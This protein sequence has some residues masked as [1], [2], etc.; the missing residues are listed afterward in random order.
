MRNLLMMEI[1]PTLFYK[2]MASPIGDLALFAQPDAR[3]R[4]VLVA[5]TFDALPPGNRYLE[6]YFKGCELRDAPL[7]GLCE[8]FEA[9][10]DGEAA[11][12]DTVE[13]SPRGT[14]FQEEVWR[15]LREI[16]AGGIESYA[17][18]SERIGRPQA[19]RAVAR[20]N[21]LNPV[22]LVVP[23][24]RV[25][26]KDG[27]LTGFGGGLDRKAWLLKHEGARSDPA[28]DLFSSL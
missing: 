27:S 9:Y 20:A 25:I 16:P 4:Q 1:S 23:C 8:A 18:L 14:T 2:K 12:L 28:P 3:G 5:A 24:H 17:A 15:A 6:R 26:G 19:V 21:A 10:F 13:A 22:P 7:R 11:R